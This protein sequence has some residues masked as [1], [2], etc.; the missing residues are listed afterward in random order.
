MFV[1]VCRLIAPY[2]VWATI[3]PVTSHVVTF[4]HSPDIQPSMMN[5]LKCRDTTW[6][7]ATFEGYVHVYMNYSMLLL[8][9]YILL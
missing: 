8:G 9:I 6:A 2:E 5:I 3:S 4:C 7:Y 1:N